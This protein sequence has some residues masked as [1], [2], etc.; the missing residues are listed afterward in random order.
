MIR[1]VQVFNQL[2]R[3]H[4]I[5]DYAIG[6]GVASLFYIEP[7]FTQD[8]D[9]FIILPYSPSKIL[10][11]SHIYDYIKNKGFK[12]VNDH[13]KIDGHLVQILVGRELESEAV[14]N[15][16]IKEIDTTKCRV[17][18][19]EYLVAIFVKLGRSR[20]IYRAIELTR[21]SNLEKLHNVLVKHDLLTKF[22]RLTGKQI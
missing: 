5:K 10:D 22:K 18:S 13:I 8:I 19:P 2:K 21:K 4:L 14:I 7:M 15:A 9:I 20:D 1:V 17:M 11:L 6:G 16:E 3:L 12:W